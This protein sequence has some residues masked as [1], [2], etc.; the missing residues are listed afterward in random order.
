M[1][2]GI[3]EFLGSNAS[4]TSTN[5]EAQ[6]ER[7]RVWATADFPGLDITAVGW[8][9]EVRFFQVEHGRLVQG[10]LNNTTWTESFV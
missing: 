7:N 5:W 9:D 1:D 8:E 10:S 4:T 3:Y 2:S 6:P